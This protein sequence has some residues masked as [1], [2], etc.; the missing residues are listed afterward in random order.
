MSR[1]KSVLN[2]HIDES[3]GHLIHAKGEDG[4]TYE[5]VELRVRTALG[6]LLDSTLRELG[7]KGLR[8]RIRDRAR[9]AAVND[10]DG[11]SEMHPSLF[12]EELFLVYPV[13][14][15][16]GTTRFKQFVHL[17]EEELGI[18]IGELIKQRKG[19]DRHIRAL[20]R[21]ERK[22]KPIWSDQPGLLIVEAQ[23][24]LTPMAAE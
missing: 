23:G 2:E 20:R 21:V 19:I 7:L 4:F 13:Q 15:P 6:D 14:E 16:S 17:N 18:Q 9:N 5:D 3:I 10:I 12:D 24:Y 1:R 22:L 11:L 8:D